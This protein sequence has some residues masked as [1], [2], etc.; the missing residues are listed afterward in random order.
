MGLTLA[1]PVCKHGAAPAVDGRKMGI[2]H[3]NIRQQETQ[4]NHPVPP[5]PV[6]RPF[7]PEL[8]TAL[9]SAFGEVPA[10]TTIG[11]FA[12]KPALVLRYLLPAHAS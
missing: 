7:P 11:Q 8:L 1:A 3:Q 6:R 12:G 10:T 4:V 5:A 9:K 2:N